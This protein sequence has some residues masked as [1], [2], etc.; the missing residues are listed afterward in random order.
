ME[1]RRLR[2]IPNAAGQEA[3]SRVQGPRAQERAAVQVVGD[4]D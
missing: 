1:K 2:A 4:F 3:G